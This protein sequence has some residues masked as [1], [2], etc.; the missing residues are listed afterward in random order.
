MKKR[1]IRRIWL[2]IALILLL[3]GIITNGCTTRKKK[4]RRLENFD[5]VDWMTDKG[6]C[7][8]TRLTLKDQLLASKYYM[9]GLKTDDIEELLGKPDAEELSDRSQKYYIYYLEPGPKCDQAKENP[10]ALFVRF[11]AVGIANEFIIRTL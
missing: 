9:R 7:N 3:S 4:I 10:Q 11:S 8:G 1:T 2:S 5:S 6:G